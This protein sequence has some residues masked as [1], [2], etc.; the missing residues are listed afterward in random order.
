M[1]A[2][3]PWPIAPPEEKVIYR[4]KEDCFLLYNEDNVLVLLS[5]IPRNYDYR[6]LVDVEAEKTL[7]PETTSIIVKNPK[8]DYLVLCVFSTCVTVIIGDQMQL[9]K[10]LVI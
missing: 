4:I 8:M 1:N 7:A 6:L 10:H 5:S 3:D 9:H 2:I